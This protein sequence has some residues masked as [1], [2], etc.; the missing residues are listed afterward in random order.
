MIYYYYSN[1]EASYLQ[2]RV[3]QRLKFFLKQIN[4]ECFSFLD[5]LIVT[6]KSMKCYQFN[7]FFHCQ[8]NAKL[9]QVNKP[10]S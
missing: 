6:H 1:N 4:K 9:S 3:K 8:L 10:F 7:F 5:H 2:I